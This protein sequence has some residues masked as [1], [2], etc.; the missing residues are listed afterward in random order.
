MPKWILLITKIFT[1]RNFLDRFVCD[2]YYNLNGG[3]YQI[4]ILNPVFPH[5]HASSRTSLST[6]LIRK[7]ISF[8]IQ[9][10]D[11]YKQKLRKSWL[12]DRQFFKE[13]QRTY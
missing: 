10:T 1:E 2:D 11:H 7:Q 5:E 6:N 9:I 13:P 3:R 4:E 12:C 8:E